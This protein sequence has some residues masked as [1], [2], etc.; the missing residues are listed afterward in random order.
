[1]FDFPDAAA[2]I[3]K[4]V[5]YAKAS[6]TLLAVGLADRLVVERHH[7]KL[8]AL[9]ASVDVVFANEAEALA[10][11]GAGDSEAAIGLLAR[12]V[13]RA[14][15]TR[16]EAGA[17]IADE[18]G[19]IEIAPVPVAEVVDLTGAGDLFAAGVCFGLTHGFDSA[20]SGRLGALC[21]SEIISH[22]GARPQTNLA[23][24][25]RERNVGIATES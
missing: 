1:L 25:A 19:V 3:D 2:I 18:H 16:G 21:A 10:L 15:V 6:D 11:S 23:D 22:L 8:M 20:T 13:R 4:L 17:L 12:H 14:V 24:L 9:L 5:H 7:E